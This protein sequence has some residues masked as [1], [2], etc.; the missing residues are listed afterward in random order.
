MG[1]GLT[2]V[3][4]RACRNKK[5]RRRYWKSV[6]MAAGPNQAFRAAGKGRNAGFPYLRN[7]CAINFAA[8][9]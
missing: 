5:L 2:S 8:L 3:I 7:T 1:S 6:L 4:G 9:E